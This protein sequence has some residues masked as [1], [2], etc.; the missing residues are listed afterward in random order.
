MAVVGC[1]TELHHDL[2]EREANEIVVLLEASGVGAEKVADAKVDGRWT[3]AVP[4]GQ[5]SSALRLMQQ[6]GLPRRDARAEEPLKA[7]SGFI[8]M[9][10]EERM[11]MEATQARRLEESLMAMDGVVD[12]RVH[13]VLPERPRLMLKAQKGGVAKASVLVKVR[14]AKASGVDEARVQK[15]VAGGVEGLSVERV[16]AVIVEEAVPVLPSAATLPSV[17]VGP[18]RVAE[19]TRVPLQAALGLLL[20]LLLL[21]SGAVVYLVLR[22]RRA[23][24]APAL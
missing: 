5:A 11:V 21:Q 16:S 7:R 8:P 20:G 17:D 23:R 6:A 15:L 10:G 19:G 4:D 9:P 24:P 2:G 12:A 3:I 13:L 1:T 22:L 14:S 18:F